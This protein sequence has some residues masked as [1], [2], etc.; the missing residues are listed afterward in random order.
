MAS[1]LGHLPARLA[2]LDGLLEAGGVFFQ[3]RTL[4]ARRQGQDQR[5]EI[6]DEL[7]LL[8]VFAVVDHL[9]V[10]HGGGVVSGEVAEQVKGLSRVDNRV[11]LSSKAEDA[12]QRQ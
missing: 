2:L 6:A 7:E 11:G 9:A 5:V 10:G 3:V 8:L 12:G 4:G 1:L